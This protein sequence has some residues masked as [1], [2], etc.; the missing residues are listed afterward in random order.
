MARSAFFTIFGQG[1]AWPEQLKLLPMPNIWHWAK[2][3]L[4]KPHQRE[5]L[6]VFEPDRVETAVL[7]RTHRPESI[8]LKVKKFISLFWFIQMIFCL[9]K[10]G[11]AAVLAIVENFS[12]FI[13]STF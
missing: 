1:M 9:Q 4:N 3:C 11:V 6:C 2:Y 13:W 12:F 8:K 10:V 5:E 7:D